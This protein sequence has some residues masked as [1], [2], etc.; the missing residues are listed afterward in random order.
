MHSDLFMG[1]KTNSHHTCHWFDGKIRISASSANGHVCLLARP[2]RGG[3]Q[4]EFVIDLGKPS[5]C[6]FSLKIE[7]DVWLIISHTIE[8]TRVHSLA[9]LR[10]RHIPSNREITV[11]RHCYARVW[12]FRILR[13]Y[14][15]SV[16][17]T[18][19]VPFEIE[20]GSNFY[21]DESRFFD[22]KEA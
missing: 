18:W 15:K 19:V 16:K 12:R 17:W 1:K 22:I 4:S 10:S 11:Q 5:A 14:L 8:L 3:Q 13:V 21:L 2:E 6:D 9:A 7:F 20:R